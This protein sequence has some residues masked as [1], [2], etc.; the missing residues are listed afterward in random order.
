MIKKIEGIIISTVD[1]KESSKIVNILTRDEGLIGVLAKGSKNPKSKIATTSNI[2]TYGIFYL[3][4]YKGSIPLLT[5]VDL[6]DSFKIIRK[7]ILKMNY[8]V[9]LLELVTQ[10]YRYDKTETVYNLL[11]NGLVKINEGYDEQIITNIIELKMLQYLGIKP[12]VDCCVNCQKKTDIV[13]ISSYKGGYLCK[14]CVGN[15]NI[16]QLKTMHLIRMFYY[17][18]LAKITK[19]DINDTIKKELSSFID[20]YYERYSGL[21]L[22]S[23]HLLEEFAKVNI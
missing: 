14:D 23:K 6:K 19:I 20:D 9:F 5:E 7:D 10:V 11:I 2:L 12:V 17:V 18:D 13:T 15:E 3:N 8:A 16:Y 1:Y 4:Y 21:Y 22:K